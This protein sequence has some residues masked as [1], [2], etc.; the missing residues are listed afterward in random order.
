[1]GR[2]D[3]KGS[4][5]KILVL[6]V[7]MGLIGGLVYLYNSAMFE[8]KKP[9]ISL[10]DNIFWNLK[11]PIPIVIRDESGVKFARVTLS[12][13]NNSIPLINKKFEK[14]KKEV[15]LEAV[16]PRT[17]FFSKKANLELKIETA[18][19]SMWNFFMGNE[20]SRKASIQI[21]TKKPFV[22]V[23]A[24]SYS[25]TQGGSAS[26]VFKADDENLE[27]LYIKTNSGDIFYPTPF[28]KKGHYIS[29]LAWQHNQKD[30]S[31]NVVA[32]DKAGNKSQKRIRFYL[33][34]KK[35]RT[36]N[37]KLSDKFID[38]KITDLVQ[39][40]NSENADS[41][42]RIERFSFINETLRNKNEKLIV[43]LTSNVPTQMISSYS[44]VPFYPL[45]SAAAV[46]S[47]GDHR[48]YSYNGS[49]ASESYHL[50]LDL[51]STAQANIVS[52]NKGEVIFSDENGIYGNNIIISHGL[53]VYSIYGHCSSFKVQ[54]G[55]IVKKGD[56]IAT[57]GIS[58]LALGDHVH[59]GILVQGIE[60]RPAEWMDKKW[61]RD[62][63]A[64]V[65]A[66]AKRLIDRK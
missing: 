7:F 56:V 39:I 6:L 65:M 29:L 45:K 63:V 46:A 47:F 50:G 28:Y 14:N 59:F 41:M 38:G 49:P 17:A 57:T 66:D 9:R 35:Y 5:G 37:I 12:D 8:Q 26:V 34:S 42:N 55:D 43:K 40:Y 64:S 3:K 19:N 2:R 21:D 58:G 11:S 27:K 32:V 61:F 20:T 4:F 51:A 44:I 54:K 16:F 33:L 15:M 62:N 60:V 30:F 24:N 31:A 25:I 53:G 10:G 18:D 13:G 52:S 48:Y 1:M 36:S 23:L 22:N